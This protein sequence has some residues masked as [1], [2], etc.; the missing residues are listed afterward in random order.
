MTDIAANEAAAEKD[1]FLASLEIGGSLDSLK[2]AADDYEKGNRKKVWPSGFPNLDYLLDGG[3]YESQLTVVGA[4]SSLGKTTWV[5][6]IAS[7][8]AEQGHDVLIFS[9]EMSKDELNAKTVSRYAYIVDKENV[10]NGEEPTKSG[11]S[12]NRRLTTFDILKGH[13]DHND[14]VVYQNYQKALERTRALAPHTYIYIGNN[15][16]NVD[17]IREITE[18]FIATT[19]KRPLV[20]LDY[21][22]IL[23]PSNNSLKNHFDTRR[24]TSDD[25]TSLKILAREN[26]IPVVVISAFNRASYTDPVSFASF[27]E[28]GGIEYSSDILLGLQFCGMEFQSSGYK[29]ERGNHVDGIESSTSHTVRVNKLIDAMQNEG[30]A[31]GQQPIQLKVLKNRN[32]PKGYCYFLFTPK[33]NYFEY[34]FESQC[35]ELTKSI[36]KEYN[37]HEELISKITEDTK[38]PGKKRRTL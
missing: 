17:K 23:T 27:K 2:Q 30:S 10:A 22:Q 6:Q 28:S 13:V 19:G 1:K 26:K 33:Y 5:M 11:K 24:S 9:L 36:V 35:V 3:F 12:T 29:D 34:S 37:K 38:A 16:E 18:R 7:Q 15:T 25:I 20:I 8:L 4:V 32:G 21:L 31:G 14:P